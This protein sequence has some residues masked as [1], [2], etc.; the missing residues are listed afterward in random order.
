MAFRQQEERLTGTRGAWSS[1]AAAPTP[2]LISEVPVVH[3]IFGA[4]PPTRSVINR[5]A[6]TIFPTHVES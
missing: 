2:G 1:D 4:N 6:M 3:E 5:L